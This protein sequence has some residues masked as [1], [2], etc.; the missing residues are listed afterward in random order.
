MIDGKH[1]SGVITYRNER[2]RLISVRRS[3]DKQVALYEGS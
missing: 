3:R 2:I 1:Y